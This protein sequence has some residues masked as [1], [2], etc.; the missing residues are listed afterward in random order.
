MPMAG[1]KEGQE[2]REMEIDGVEQPK[3]GDVRGAELGEAEVFLTANAG[4]H[5]ALG[6]QDL[7]QAPGDGGEVIAGGEIEQR[8]DKMGVQ[9]ESSGPGSPDAGHGQGGAFL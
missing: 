2:F 1:L 3:I 6:G 8:R 7:D 5:A 9:V 4:E